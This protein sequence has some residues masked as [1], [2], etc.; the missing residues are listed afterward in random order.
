MKALIDHSPLAPDG[1]GRI[2]SFN[3][4]NTLLLLGRWRRMFTIPNQSS[5][6]K[7]Y[8]EFEGGRMKPSA[9]YALG[10]FRRFPVTV[11]GAEASQ[12]R[13]VKIAKAATSR[14]VRTAASVRIYV[15]VASLSLLFDGPCLIR[16]GECGPPMST[17][18]TKVT[19]DPRKT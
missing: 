16:P 7:A 19:L 11:L 14:L 5:V 13:L 2:Q 10:L 4:V 6:A 12:V 9:Y 3:A 17:R 8:D 15:P 1:V 18:I